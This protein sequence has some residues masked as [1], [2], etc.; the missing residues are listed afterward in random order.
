MGL[1]APRTLTEIRLQ[2]YQASVWLTHKC[3]PSLVTLKTLLRYRFSFF[4]TSTQATSTSS[5][6]LKAF[7]HPY[8]NINPQSPQLSSSITLKDQPLHYST[9]DFIDL[10]HLELA[11]SFTTYST[12]AIFITHLYIAFNLHKD[13]C[14]A[15]IRGQ[16]RKLNLLTFELRKRSR[17]VLPNFPPLIEP[18]TD[19]SLQ[20]TQNLA[21]LQSIGQS[22]LLSTTTQPAVKTGTYGRN[23]TTRYTTNKRPL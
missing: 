5:L 19:I 8:I 21:L 12:Q 11:S 18:L 7:P 4:H 14:N 2:L 13:L 17:Y 3:V 10:Y 9:T 23:T 1:G 6:T 22:R 15:N 16:L 20:Q